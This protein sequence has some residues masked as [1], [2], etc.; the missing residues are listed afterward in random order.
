[1]NAS[2]LH[3]DF[4]TFSRASLKLCG[5]YQYARHPTT[6]ILV[7]CWAINEDDVDTWVPSISKAQARE[8]GLPAHWYYGPRCPQPLAAAVRS[9][10]QFAA[11]NAQFERAI[12]QAVVVRRHGGPT[13][14]RS[15]FVC[16]AARSAASGLPRSL[17]GV[18]SALG[19]LNQKDKEGSRLLKLFAMPRKPTKTDSRDR[20]QPID[21]IQDFVALCAYCAQDVRAERDVD[22]LVPQLHPSE[23]K[24]FEFDMLINERGL[25]ID[26]KLVAKTSVVVAALELAIK[27]EVNILTKSE[28]YPEGLNPTQGVKIK[29]F[30]ADQGVMLENLKKDY[31]NKYLLKNASTIPDVTRRLLMLR[32]EASKASTKKLASMLA[33]CGDDVLE[34]AR[35]TLLFSGAH[36]GRW[37]G[38]GIQPHNFIRGTLKY[39]E[40][41]RVL[42][43]L[44][45]ADHEVFE[46]LYEWPISRIAQ[47]MRG[48]ITAP[49]GKILRVV[50]YSSIEARVLAWLAQ[51]M[52][53]LQI[54]I[55]GLDVYKVMAGSVYNTPYDEVTSEQRRIGKNL[56]LGCG[57]G[58]GGA[59]FVSYSEAA[60]VE[61]E[62]AFAKAAVKKYRADHPNIVRFWG[63]V[64]KAAVLAV[65]SERTREN[66]VVLRNLKFFVEEY[67]FCIQLPGGRCLRYFKP[68]VIAT[69]KFGEPSLALT[70]KSEIR[71]RLY[72]EQTYGGKLVENIT[73][74]VAR[75]LLVSGMWAAEAAGYPVYGTV[76]DEIITETDPD[77]GSHQELEKI[78]CQ[79][80]QWAAGL[81]VAAEGFSSVR[82]RK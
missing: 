11:H 47:C 82:Y 22:A 69:E 25:R 73:Q 1:M 57:Y 45:H 24:L 61:I 23:Q 9:G 32:M 80:P 14:R 71:G 15:Q 60:G 74:A 79:L 2:T 8:L 48:F 5:T 4:E 33:Y 40:Q 52:K 53:V 39:D 63:D 54:Y 58:L 10:M 77:W 30:F 7:C 31:L 76:H 38:K 41:L 21:A 43:L 59:K 34:R 28:Q 75:D 64:E 26:T 46:L 16:T 50:D 81:P 29:Q 78:V 66:P 27:K 18:A 56:V 19:V 70:Y 67:W 35:G 17:D 37:S 13:T 20:I 72:P 49:P 36:T 42:S 68:K 6:E 44:E 62:E 3:V 51:E 12:W 55:D 65:R